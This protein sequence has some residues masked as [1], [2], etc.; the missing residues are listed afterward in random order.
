MI[1]WS[2]R[3]LSIY[4][5]VK[6][7]LDKE[8][9]EK[10]LTI[11]DYLGRTNRGA[12]F[13]INFNKIH[14][15]NLEYEDVISILEDIGIALNEKILEKIKERILE[16]RTVRLIWDQN[17]VLL[18]THIYLGEKFNKIRD[19]VTYDRRLRKIYVKPIYFFELKKKLNELGLR[20]IDETGL[21]GSLKLPF[22]IKLNVTLR[23]YQKEALNTWLNK[24]AKGVIA[25]PTGAG[26]TIIAIAAMAKLSER[27][28][29]VT[30]TKEQMFQWQ[31]MI[32]K[33]T[34]VK[35]EYIGLYYG[36]EKRLSPITISTYQTA[37]RHIDVLTKYFS[38]LIIDE[39]HHLPSDKFKY[40]AINSFAPKRMGL[41]ATVVR[42]DGKHEELFPLMG[43]VV[44]YKSPSDLAIRGYLA[45]YIIYPIEVT[46]TPDEYK[47]YRELYKVYKELSGGE[48]FEMIL[49]KARRGDI[50]AQNALRIHSKLRQIVHKSKSKN[51][52]VRKIVDLELKKGS[53]II[54]F[55]Q[56]V[57]Q[58]KELGELLNAPILIGETETRKRQEI[59]RDFKEGKTRVLVVTTVGDE[60]LD[61]PDANVGI[62]VTGTGSRRQFI[63]RLGRLL[64]PSEGKEARLYEIIVKGTLEEFQ[65]RRRKSFDLSELLFK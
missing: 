56:Y 43:G 58:A 29:I 47:E 41:S 52:I 33:F 63:Q 17:R 27:T 5:E 22:N 44:Y 46:L 31:D 62:I 37:Y 20:V 38:F 8:D 11:A 34:D 57:D 59:L 7:W 36:E 55:T 61:I 2:E 16:K 14:K 13:V 49:E 35:K 42:E 1:T 39:V 19:F 28:L 24:G 12:K 25:L 23:D 30:Y 60:G 48:K 53:K 26:K 51:K 21:S 54:V 15:S 10:L 6:K 4:F 18:Q 50:R 9:Y 3:A 64:R 40:I 65:S 32:V 45:P